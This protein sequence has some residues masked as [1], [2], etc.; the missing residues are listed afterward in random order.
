MFSYMD[1]NSLLDNNIDDSVM[2]KIEKKLFN[3]NINLTSK[4]K[5]F[6]YGDYVYNY[7]LGKVKR[8]KTECVPPEKEYVTHLYG[9]FWDEVNL[10]MDVDIGYLTDGTLYDLDN[11]KLG[12]YDKDVSKLSDLMQKASYYRFNYV[13]NSAD[14]FK[15]NNVELKHRS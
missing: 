14:Q 7:S 5:S 4:I 3:D 15:L 9:Y 11:N 2:K 6:H 13:K 8:E 10:Y 12:T 1:K